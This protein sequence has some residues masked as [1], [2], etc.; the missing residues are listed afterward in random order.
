MISFNI[1]FIYL[2]IREDCFDYFMRN[3]KFKRE[4]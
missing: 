3:E 1:V 4:K 2:I